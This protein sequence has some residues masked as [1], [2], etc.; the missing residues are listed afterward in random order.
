M[1]EISGVNYIENKM[2]GVPKTALKL[3]IISDLKMQFIEDFQAENGHEQV[4]WYVDLNAL[5]ILD[6]WSGII[7]NSL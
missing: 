5:Q 4:R 6:L 7:F 2:I 3:Q 1:A